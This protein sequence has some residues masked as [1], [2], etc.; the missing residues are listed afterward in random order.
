MK[1]ILLVDDEQAVRESLRDIFKEKGYVV[2]F[3]ANGNEALK[4]FES[5]RHPVVLIDLVMPDL[6]GKMLLDAIKR[7]EPETQVVIITG[8]PMLG[9]MLKSFREDIVRVMEK[10]LDVEALLKLIEDLLK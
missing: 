5:Q 10:P 2:D 9:K 7:L 4:L 1:K 3:A 6:D 8:Y